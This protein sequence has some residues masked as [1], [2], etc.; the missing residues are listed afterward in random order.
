M[1]EQEFSALF[2]TTGKDGKR[3]TI[4]AVTGKR[5]VK[6]DSITR[7]RLPETR[8]YIM[9]TMPL[10]AARWDELIRLAKAGPQKATAPTKEK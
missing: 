4:C 10:S 8:Y 5:L 6:T 3:P 2:G 9:Y 1:N 7:Q